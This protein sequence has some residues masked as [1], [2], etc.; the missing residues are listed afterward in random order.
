MQKYSDNITNRSGQVIVGASVTV[1]RVD[2][3]AVTLYSDNGVTVRANPLTTDANG[4][5]EFYAADGR[6]NLTIN[7]NGIRQ[8]AIT[9]ILLEDPADGSAALAAASGSS[10]VGHG[11]DT[12]ANALNALRLADYPALRAYAGA[13]SSV[14]ITSAG[15]AGMFVRDDADITSADNGGTIIVA[16]NGK[17]WKRVFSGPAHVTWFGA[18]GD[19]TLTTAQESAAIQA[20]INA[21]LAVYFPVP[22]LYYKASNV[23]LRTGV[24]LLGDAQWLGVEGGSAGNFM[25]VGDG[26]NPV[27]KT[28]VYPGSDGTQNRDITVI[29]ISARNNG[30][31]VVD[32]LGANNFKFIRCAFAT[33]SFADATKGTLNIRYSYRGTIQDCNITA[34]GGAWAISAYDNVNGLNGQNNIITG[35]SAGGAVDIGQAQNVQFNNSIIEQSLK[36]FRVGAS[37]VTG[38]GICNSVNL[39]DNYLEEVA[40]PYEIGTGFI[41]RGLSIKRGFINN[42]NI[43]LAEDNYFRLGRVQGWEIGG[44]I[45]I[46]RKAGGTKEL[47][48]FQYTAS[49]PYMA[50][51]GQASDIYL[52]N[53]SG[54]FQKLTSFPSPVY[55]GYLTGLNR[56]QPTI[57]QSTSG[58]RV[59][60]SE[61]IT[62]NIGKT[63]VA[64]VSA[65]PYGGVVDAVEVFDATGTLACTVAIGT[66]AAFSEITSFDPSS[67][68]YTSGAAI[69]AISDGSSPVS[70][71]VLFRAGE[72][73]KLTV[74]AGAGTGSFRIRVKW[75]GL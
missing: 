45:S 22:S 25:L 15:I 61:R 65:A 26:V 71:A 69:A 54:A 55:L 16:A 27:F 68:T 2:G 72:V 7:G 66:G 11:T 49:V 9:D 33:F 44:G 67:L 17:R 48:D 20:A 10:L 6:Y 13:Q 1:S 18:K 75:R 5:F 46:S 51:A 37:G 14:F 19:G 43:S 60:E 42:S 59:W 39:D 50:T 28:G 31:Q 47:F 70:G 29:G 40:T 4:Y 52:A 34:S 32:W 23:Q 58:M 30:A 64:M 53:G 24:T 73:M 38:A 63:G 35:G 62:A 74:T 12:V 57:G 8:Y 56:I 21:H 3:G 36:G 41:V